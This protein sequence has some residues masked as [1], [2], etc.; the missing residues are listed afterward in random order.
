MSSGLPSAFLRS[1]LNSSTARI[2]SPCSSPAG[3]VAVTNFDSG[4]TRSTSED[5]FNGTEINVAISAR[6]SDVSSQKKKVISVQRT[7][8][9]SERPTSW[10]Q[11][12]NVKLR[13]G[14]RRVALRRISIV[15]MGVTA[16]CECFF[17]G[18]QHTVY[19]V[20]DG[21]FIHSDLTNQHYYYIACIH[22]ICLI[23]THLF[24]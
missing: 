15:F 16:L 7:Q 6:E 19:N 3:Y 17:I 14:E 24:I 9:T 2:Y 22:I 18:T 8:T 5:F 13:H 11:T 4:F 1:L 23:V 12:E 10:T 21:S 20:C